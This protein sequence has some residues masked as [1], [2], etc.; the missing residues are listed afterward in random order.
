MTIYKFGTGTLIITGPHGYRKEYKML[1]ATI[2]FTDFTQPQLER[3]RELPGPTVAA[4]V[5]EDDNPKPVEDMTDDE[6]EQALANLPWPLDGIVTDDDRPTIERANE[7][8]HEQD[9]RAR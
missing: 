6:L 1:E 3:M 4:T 7:L 8:M 5:V 9:R 2:E